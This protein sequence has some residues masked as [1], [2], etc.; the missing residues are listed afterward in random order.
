M[1][2]VARKWSASFHFPLWQVPYEKLLEDLEASSVLCTV[3]ATAAPVEGVIHVGDVFDRALLS[4]LP[5]GV[6]AFGEC[7]E[8]HTLARVWHSSNGHG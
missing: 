3:S 2:E 7:G 1:S 6:D 8:F 5:R 4:R